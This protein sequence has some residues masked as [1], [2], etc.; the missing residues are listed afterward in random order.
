M[1]YSAH[2]AYLLTFP[3]HDPVDSGK[4]D[5]RCGMGVVGR[6]VDKWA[7]MGL[8][9]PGAFGLMAVKRPGCPDRPKR[10]NRSSPYRASQF[11]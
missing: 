5:R 8:L 6:N 7:I 1:L 11:V 2:I 3:S 9:E 4:I 10:S